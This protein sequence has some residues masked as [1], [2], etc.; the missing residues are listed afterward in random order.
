MR[1][2][3]IIILSFSLFLLTSPLGFALDPVA[4]KEERAFGFFKV[5]TPLPQSDRCEL[6]GVG[7]SNYGFIIPCVP[8]QQMKVPI[9]AY[10]LSVHLQGNEWLMP[11]T[12]TPTEYTK[13]A[14]TGF[15]NLKVIGAGPSDMVEVASQDGR[16][17][18]RFRAS[19]VKTIPVGVY[20]VKINTSAESIIKSNVSIWPNTT[21][22][23]IVSFR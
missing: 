16:I 1:K 11:L 21:R 7:L 12:V 4:P 17:N 10:H 23:L 20:N 14:V 9:G 6:R 8:G 3:I 13:V 5:D 19:E 18:E 2:F 22:E 15:G